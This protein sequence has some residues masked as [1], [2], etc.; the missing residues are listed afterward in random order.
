MVGH[1]HNEKNMFE[2]SAAIANNDDDKVDSKCHM[3]FKSRLNNNELNPKE[4]RN[5]TK[6]KR[7][8][9][10]TDLCGSDQLTHVYST[11]NC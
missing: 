10:A 1:Q 5:K 7:T 2:K 8:N 4:I 6:K 9:I 11:A 3:T